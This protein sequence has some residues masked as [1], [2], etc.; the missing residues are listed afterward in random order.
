MKKFFIFILV[1]MFSICFDNCWALTFDELKNVVATKIQKAQKYP[2]IQIQISTHNDLMDKNDIV[3]DRVNIT[4]KD[5][6]VANV[7][8]G[9]RQYKLHGVYHKYISAPAAKYRISKGKVIDEDDVIMNNFPI[10]LIKP[11][12]IIE[13]NQVVGM[14][15]K[16]N[17]DQNA[18]FKVNDLKPLI[19]IAKGD[20]V[21]VQFTRNN[22]EIK[23]TGAA[24]NS[25]GLGNII[26]VKIQDTN[27]IV[28]GQI[29]SSSLVQ[30]KKND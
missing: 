11:T 23:A 5:K 14:V 22:L 21:T 24:L 1:L 16:R 2:N 28:I 12:T 27:K 30:I 29:L 26:K 9:H 25:G 20:L 4:T 3:F 19:I 17:I 15:S 10:N 18:L 8:L 13:P 6:F 7:S